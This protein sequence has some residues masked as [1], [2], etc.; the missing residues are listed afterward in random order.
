M[1]PYPKVMKFD[2]K[3]NESRKN[4]K[5]FNLSEFYHQ[6]VKSKKKKYLSNMK[7]YFTLLMKKKKQKYRKFNH[8][9][10]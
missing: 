5:S 7:I 1:P 4:C 9:L 3:M 6:Y 10:K 8:N 2:F